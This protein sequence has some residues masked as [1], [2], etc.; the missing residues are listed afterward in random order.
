MRQSQRRYFSQSACDCRDCVNR[1]NFRRELVYAVLVF[2]FLV[3][4]FAALFV[5]AEALR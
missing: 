2:I 5:I 1:S 3:A 4:S